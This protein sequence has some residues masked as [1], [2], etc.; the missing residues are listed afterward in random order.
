MCG[1]VASTNRDWVIQNYTKLGHR[2]PDCVS[3]KEFKHFTMAHLR[4]SIVGITDPDASQPYCDRNCCCCFNGEIFNYRDFGLSEIQTLVK[5]I[6]EG[7]NL[8]QLLNGY[9]GICYYDFSR[10]EVVLYRDL[11]GVI[12]LYYSI[13]NG[14]IFIASEKKILGSCK[15]VMP[16]SKVTISLDT[17]QEKTYEYDW[18]FTLTQQED[19]DILKR[20]FDR[21]I[22][23]VALHSDCGFD[24]A[25][26][27]GLDST[28]V[29]YSLKEQNIIP[30]SIITVFTQTTDTSELDRAKQV[31]KNLGWEN[32]HII[33]K[34]E[35]FDVRPWIESPINP[36][37]D[38]AFLRHATVAKYSKS[39]V[40][41]CGE[42]AD[43]LG[44]GYPV[45][46]KL[47]G[48]YD[49]FLKKIS[50]LKSQDTMTLDR[51]NKSGMMFSKEYRVPFLDKDFSLLALGYRQTQKSAFR[52]MGQL[53][54]IDSNILN[55]AKYSNEETEGRSKWK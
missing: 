14:D 35:E 41:L 51:T 48:P 11:Y 42:G 5:L 17:M 45:S 44:L 10:N 40:I 50:L 30:Q 53:Y 32:L 43:E 39:K 2:G 47:K 37:K 3:I 16:N 27:G 6:R 4:L 20:A 24:V 29:L 46:R 19:L 13:K 12:P 38:F 1:I 54:G 55:C 31:V 36:I 26:S 34:C 25:Y 33:K 9:F 49:E 22:K 28:L 8:T 18:P 52:K 23:R 7:H 15:R 21:A